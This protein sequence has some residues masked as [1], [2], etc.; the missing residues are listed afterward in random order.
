LA[1]LVDEWRGYI[2][3]CQWVE[4]DKVESVTMYINMIIFGVSRVGV[5]STMILQINTC[6]GMIFV[7]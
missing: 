7:V 3:M 2:D 4:G 5:I 6:N 1:G